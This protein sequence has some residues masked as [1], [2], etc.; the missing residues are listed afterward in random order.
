MNTFSDRPE[1]ARARY[2]DLQGYPD[3][4]KAAA[5]HRRAELLDRA[6]E[7]IERSAIA[8]QKDYGT[9]EAVPTAVARSNRGCN[10]ALR[11]APLNRKEEIKMLIQLPPV[12]RGIWDAQQALA[13]HYA[14]TGLMFTLDGRLVGDIAEAVALRHFDLRV[15]QTRTKG[16]DA[17]TRS[18]KSVQVK[19]TGRSNAGP[20]FTT[21]TGVAD[22]LLFFQI[23]FEAG[24]ARVVYNGPES[25]VR[26]LLPENLNGTHVVKLRDIQALAS[27]VASHELLPIG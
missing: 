5:R 10:A 11:L 9:G 27:G 24:T 12:V 15:P 22:Y 19:A 20:A 23:N 3:L 6:R 16:V 2:G 13:E 17:L 18:G 14:D 26:A 4:R 25:P 8:T 1:E 21:G 7:G